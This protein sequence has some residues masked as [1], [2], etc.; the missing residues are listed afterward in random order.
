MNDRRHLERDE[1]AERGRSTAAPRE[2][3]ENPETAAVLDLQER[4]GNRAVAGMLE[5]RPAD[6]R[7]AT[8]QLQPAGQAP[9]AEPAK[10]EKTSAGATMTI[11]EMKLSIPILSYSLQS[12]RPDTRKTPTGELTVSMAL[13]DLD[14]RIAQAVARGDR[15]ETITVEA[16]THKITMKGVM[17]SSSQIGGEIATLTLSFTS[18]DF[19][20]GEQPPSPDE[21]GGDYAL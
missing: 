3:N 19:G 5:T 1:N 4:A 12:G 7:G 11:P 17:F 20:Q 16:G 14:P 9:T 15:F 21:G 10:D 18:I 8:L 6:A 2:R 13:K